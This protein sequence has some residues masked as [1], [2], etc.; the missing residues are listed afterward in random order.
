MLVKY[1]KIFFKTLI[2]KEYLVFLF[3]MG[4]TYKQYKKK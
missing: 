1:L 2:Y 4:N 3:K